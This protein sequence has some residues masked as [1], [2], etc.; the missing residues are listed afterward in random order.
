[1]QRISEPKF[2]Q[3]QYTTANFYALKSILQLASSITE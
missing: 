3:L 2:E 1:M